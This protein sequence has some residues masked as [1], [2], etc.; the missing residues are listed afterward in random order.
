[1]N[2]RKYLNHE[3]QLGARV[4]VDPA[5]TVIGKVW[6]ADDV[7]VWPGTVLRGDVKD[8]R[9]GA[10]TNIQDLSILHTNWSSQT[11][12]EGSPLNIGEDVTIGHH[13]TLHG[14]TIGNRVLVGM[15]SII[16]DD[17]VIGDDTI[18]G[19]GSL[20][21]PRKHLEGGFLYMGSPVKAV[22]PLTEEERAFLLVSAQNYMRTAANYLAAE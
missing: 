21:P 1:M 9:V 4:Y 20:V 12:P 15:G 13:V 19:A 6:L 14:C 18:I 8:I 16:L 22:R 10:R 5:A 7:S 3:P 11:R 2:L 17:A